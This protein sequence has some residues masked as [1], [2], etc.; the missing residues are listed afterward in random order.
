MDFSGKYVLVTG[1]SRGIGRAVAKAFAGQGAEVAIHYK[2]NLK[3]AE[4]TLKS[5][6]GG[7]HF[8]V[9]A[10]IAQPGPA[11]QLVTKPGRHKPLPDLLRF[12]HQFQCLRPGIDH[13]LS[14]CQ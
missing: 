7:S 1:G 10:D 4:E 9:R 13:A 14:G 2:T 3:A 8:I 6:G 11:Q 5:L 12:K